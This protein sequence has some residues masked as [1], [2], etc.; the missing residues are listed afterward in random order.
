MLNRKHKVGETIEGQTKPS[1]N[2][3]L[4]TPAVNLFGHHIDSQDLT[5]LLDTMEKTGLH[6]DPKS[7]E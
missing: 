5:A 3:K 4:I 2:E 6:I 1:Y 7:I